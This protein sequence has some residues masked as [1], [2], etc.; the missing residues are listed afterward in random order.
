MP[1]NQQLEQINTFLD[2]MLL[3]ANLSN[4]PDT[5]K[6]EYKDRLFA[7]IQKRIGI[8]ALN[9]LSEKDAEEFSNLVV[10][11]QTTQDDV[12]N[13]LR[14]RVTDLQEK[15]TEVLIQFQNEFVKGAQDTRL[16]MS[17]YA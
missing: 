7:E 13:F 5:F 1:I 6:D 16:Q 15:I 17:W 2:E 4:L 11:T 3:Q 8:M 9:N 12:M 10:K 14:Q